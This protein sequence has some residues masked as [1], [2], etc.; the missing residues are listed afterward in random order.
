MLIVDYDRKPKKLPSE[1]QRPDPIVEIQSPVPSDWFSQRVHGRLDLNRG[2]IVNTR[3]KI[4]RN[5]RVNIK[6]SEVYNPAVV[7]MKHA[8][9]AG[10][11]PPITF[12]VFPR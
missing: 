6:F 5:K 12:E 1:P 7:K 8:L 3:D 9:R 2:T 4:G 10:N 11:T